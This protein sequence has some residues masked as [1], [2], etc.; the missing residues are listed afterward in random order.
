[1]PSVPIKP[2]SRAEI[3]ARWFGLP[4][5]LVEA[6]APEVP[7]AVAPLAVP[8]AGKIV[9][10]AGASG[11]GKSSL[12]RSTRAAAAVEPG[13]RAVDLGA[14]GLDWA[15]LPERRVIDV[16]ADALAA[17]AP[18]CEPLDAVAEVVAALG[19]LGQVGLAEA[20]VCLRRPAALSDGQRWRLRL[21]TGL[22]DAGWRSAAA[23]ATLQ[24]V[25]FVAKPQAAGCFA[26]PQA[27][28]AGRRVVLFADEFAAVL[29]R[30]TAAAVARALRRAVD[31]SDTPLAAVLATSHDDLIDALQPDGIVRCDF[32]A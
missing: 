25:D 27:A 3:V 7:P 6:D 11:A 17:H 21:A 26:K 15:G 12:L 28:A 30:V 31:R 2:S 24:T 5:G 23:R 14:V 1:M 20:R 16:V 10:I 22:A 8:G 32:G 18:P 4:P 19:L 29:D 9:L 13:V